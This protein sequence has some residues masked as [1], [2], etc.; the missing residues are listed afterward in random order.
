MK[1]NKIVVVSLRGI[2]K[3]GDVKKTLENEKY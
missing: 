3:A 2:Q 1:E